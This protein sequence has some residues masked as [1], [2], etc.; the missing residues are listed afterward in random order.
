MILYSVLDLSPIIQG[1]DAARSFRNTL[2]LAQHAENWGYHRYWLAEHH[3]IAGIASAATSVVIGH[4]A[5]GTSRIRVGSGGVMLPNHAPLVIAEQFGTL[6]SLYPGRIDLGLGRAPGGDP[7][8]ERALRRGLGSSGATFPQDLLELQSYFAPPTAGQPLKAIPGA[9]LEVPI[10]LLGS[11]DFSARLAADLGL[12][13]AFASHF[14][15][16]FLHEA[17]AIYRGN[18]RPSPQLA[19]PYVMIGVNVFA[20][21]TDAEAARLFTSLQQAF[22]GL[23][24]GARSELAPPV[25]TMEGRWSQLEASHV[26]SMTRCSAVGSPETVRRELGALLEVTAADEIICTAQIFDHSARLR[27]HEIAAGVLQEINGRSGS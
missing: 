18:F 19:A 12:P 4:V 8:T 1:G 23:I 5:G 26:A 2:D 17:L 13:F 14:A 7:L 24:R 22:L 21:D 16:G 10:Y 11:S 15:P 6:E 27:S 9:G 3:N 25:E 20:A